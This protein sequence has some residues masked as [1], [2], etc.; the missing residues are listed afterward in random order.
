MI[1]VVF[2]ICSSPWSCH[3]T[4]Q[5]MTRIG[6]II[7]LGDVLGVCGKKRFVNVAGFKTQAF[8]VNCFQI[9]F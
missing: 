2:R 8:P 6:L 4:L 3:A 9:H 5:V 1:K 7:W